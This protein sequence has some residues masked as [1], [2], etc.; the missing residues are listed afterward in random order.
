MISAS[1]LGKTKTV[2]QVIAISLLMISMRHA[3][4]MPL[5]SLSLYL[6]VLFSMWSAI[7]YFRRFWRM[8]DTNIKHRRRLELLTVDRQRRRALFAEK[9]GAML[10]RRQAKAEKKRAD[11][12]PQTAD[13]P[14]ST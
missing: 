11:F 13:L 12:A 14:P 5:A 1:E 4:V 7:A 2:F 8:L 9:R 10:A 3:R 6:V